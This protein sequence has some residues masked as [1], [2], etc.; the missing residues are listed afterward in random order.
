MLILRGN[1]LEE[2]LIYKKSYDFAVEVFRVLHSYLNVSDNGVEF[3]SLVKSCANIA[4]NI[5][6][7]VYEESP[8]DFIAKMKL[9]LKNARETEYW[10]DLL[11]ESRSIYEEEEWKPAINEIIE[12]LETIVENAEKIEIT[13]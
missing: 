1:I 13:I 2:N 3:V 7:A 4:L 11:T 6:E 8:E 9:A 5:K 12:T 10:I